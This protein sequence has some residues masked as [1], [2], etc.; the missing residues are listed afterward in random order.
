MDKIELMA[1]SAFGIESILAEE[2]KWLG[3]NDLKV[4]NGK[5]SFMADQNAIARCNLWLR[6]ADRLFIKVGQFKTLTFDELFEGTR[7][8]PWDEL[9]P[10]NAAFPVEGKSVKSKLFSVSD[11]QAIVKKAIVEKMKSKY[12][13]NWLPVK[14]TR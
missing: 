14:G 10:E 6:T 12:K 2:L 4:E 3:Y 11:C 13:Q 7:A 8:L 1:T 5:V 9:I